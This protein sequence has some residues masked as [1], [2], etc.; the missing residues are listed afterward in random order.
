MELNALVEHSKPFLNWIIDWKAR[1]KPLPIGELM[2]D[3]PQSVGII[4]VDVIKGFCTVGPLSSPR[5]NNIVEPITRLF[6]LA[7]DRGVRDIALPQDTHVPDAVEFAQYAPHCIRGTDE[8]DTVEAFKA[9]PF[10]DQIAVFP[11]NSINSALA[12]GFAEWVSTRPQITNWLIVGDCTDLCT[13]QLAMHMRIAA[14]QNQRRG[15]RVVLPVDC[16]DTY[17]LPVET[18][19]QT[20]AVPHDAELLHLVFL[21]HMMLN[22]VEVVTEITP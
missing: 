12:P 11:K 20:G 19:K 4:S 3:G 2:G 9:L 14:N 16:V 17:D 15:V 21:Y 7:W 10:F 8:S 13:Y 1:L 5:V 22:G 6:Q 18:A